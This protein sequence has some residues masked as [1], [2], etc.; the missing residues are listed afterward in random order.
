[1]IKFLKNLALSRKRQFFGKNILPISS[2]IFWLK[3]LENH[4]IGPRSETGSEAEDDARKPEVDDQKNMEGQSKKRSG[5][6]VITF[7]IF[8]PRVVLRISFS[9]IIQKKMMM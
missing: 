2:P 5:T 3:Y 6:N 4:N 1:M 9:H 7:E 8:S